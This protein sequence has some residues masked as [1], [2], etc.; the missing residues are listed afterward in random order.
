MV[1]EDRESGE[2]GGR[3]WHAGWFSAASPEMR[4]VSLIS[5]STITPDSATTR[6]LV[7][8]VLRSR[9]V[10]ERLLHARTFGQLDELVSPA[11]FYE[12]KLVG[13]SKLSTDQVCTGCSWLPRI[14][15]LLSQTTT[16]L[17]SER[18][19]KQHII[20]KDLLLWSRFIHSDNSQIR[21][22]ALDVAKRIR[23]AIPVIGPVKLWFTI[24]T[25]SIS[26]NIYDRWSMTQLLRFIT[27]KRLSFSSEGVRKREG[28]GA[29]VYVTEEEMKI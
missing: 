28:R 9:A 2:N 27:A 11:C 8:H 23:R 25:R 26:E 3:W 4:L 7:S 12:L 21:A 19:T 14:L 1:L 6:G 22:A 20:E 5:S 10:S 24:L 16:A 18:P 17:L 15:R 13:H 29:R